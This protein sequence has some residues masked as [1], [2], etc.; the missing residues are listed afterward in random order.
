[1]SFNK[2]TEH[3]I[4]NYL[5]GNMTSE[6]MED[7]ENER[8]KNKDLD[9]MVTVMERMSEIYGDE[10]W[11]SIEHD[12]DQLK[13]AAHV[14]SEDDVKD[15]SN[16]IKTAQSRYNSKGA[17]NTSKV[18][19]YITSVAAIGLIAFFV[20]YFFIPNY[21]SEGLFESYYSTQDLPSFVLQNTTENKETIAEQLFRD[22]KY[23]EALEVFTHIDKSSNEL[24]PNVTLY[25]ALCYLEL[26]N[27]T[28]A[29]DQLEDLEQSNTIDFHKAYWFKALVYLK[30]DQK[31]DA[32]ENLKIISEN[33]TYFNYLKAIDLLDKLEQI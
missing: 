31:Q 29:L 17:K 21:T 9:D 15:F 2:D 23:T 27:Y 5:D 7:F 1:M 24:N 12:A 4:I 22:D 13:T 6:E 32:I 16:T 25:T 14:F 8:L 20:N 10:T 30:Q 18:I 33:E 11:T 28:S 26:E 3:R 19:K